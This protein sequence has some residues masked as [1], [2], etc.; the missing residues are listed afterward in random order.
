[1]V[2]LWRHAVKGVI[3]TLCSGRTEANESVTKTEDSF[4]IPGSGQA[5]AHRNFHR[6]LSEYHHGKAELTSK[7]KQLQGN[8]HLP[9][10]DSGL[11][12]GASLGDS[13][14]F[15]PSP[16]TRLPFKAQSLGVTHS[17]VIP[18][19]GKYNKDTLVW[20]TIA[21]TDLAAVTDSS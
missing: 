3:L 14:F 12:S 1:M 5:V 9:S 11:D 2:R 6:L 21:N 10:P 15:T 17:E 19:T 20:N 16:I 4:T 7:Y 8:P 18:F 13:S